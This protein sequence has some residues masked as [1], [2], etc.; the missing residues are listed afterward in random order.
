M[1]GSST[2]VDQGPEAWSPQI[3]TSLTQLQSEVV[4]R[5]SV[6]VQSRPRQALVLLRDGI[7][8]VGDNQTYLNTELDAF[9]RVTF[10]DETHASVRF[11]LKKVDLEFA[12]AA[13]AQQFRTA[14]A[15]AAMVP[16]AGQRTGV[17]LRRSDTTAHDKPMTAPPTSKGWYDRDGDPEG[18]QRWHDGTKWTT[19]INGGQ[20]QNELHQAKREQ[21]ATSLPNRQL[22]LRID[23]LEEQVARIAESDLGYPLPQS[24]SSPSRT[25]SH[26]ESSRSTRGGIM[27]EAQTVARPYSETKRV[28]GARYVGDAAPIAGVPLSRI[29]NAACY[30]IS[31]IASLAVSTQSGMPTLSLVLFGLAAI[32]Y[33]VKIVVTRGSYWVSS[34]VYVVAVFAV[35]GVFGVFAQ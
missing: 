9:S 18:V 17:A 24:T 13:D 35:V 11:S 31:G 2:P 33:G 15:L 1:T 20:A 34:V 22:T 7:A 23:A 32:G 12:S 8:I 16:S 14:V 25:R 21:A 28:G 3:V 26:L 4:S 5:W 30:I 10:P 6:T 27:N 29:L 19:K